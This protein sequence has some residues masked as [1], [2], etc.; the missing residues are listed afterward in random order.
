MRKFVLIHFLLFMIIAVF[1]K[2]PWPFLLLTVAQIVYVPIALRFVMKR[3]DWF[4]SFYSYFAIP[5]YISIAIIQ[6]FS[7]EWSAIPAI[8]YLAFTVIIAL[9]GLTRFLRRGF[10]NIEEFSIDLGMMYI[11]LGGGWYF[12][13]IADIDTGFTPLL[14]WLTGIHFHYSALLL[15]IFIGLL[16]RLYKP[17]FYS[18]F[19]GLLLAAPMVVAI[20]ITFSRWIELFSVLLYIVG[21]AGLIAI[22]WR[23]RFPTRMQ[24]WL[25]VTSF[26][27]LGLTIVFSLLYVLGNGFGLTSI[28]I[29]FML[30]FHG[31][32]N[33][34]V[35]ALFGIVGWAL[36]VPS[37]VYEEP[38][39]PIS[40]VKGKQ[41]IEHLGDPGKHRGLVDNMNLYGIN[42]V[43]PRILDFYENTID[44]RLF[45]TVHWHAWFKPFAFLYSFISRRTEQINLPLHRN[46]V[47]MTGDILTIY[48]GID[49]RKDVRAWI[50]KVDEQY[51]FVALYSSHQTNEGR[52]FMNI[53]LP[54][55]CST[56]TG[57]LEMIEH[58]DDLQLTSRKT[59]P[60][61]DAGIYLTTK[62]GKYFSLPLE[63]DFVVRE[64]GDGSLTARHEMWIFSIPFLTIHYRIHKE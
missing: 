40:R 62:L 41:R 50:R 48:D 27:S 35:F 43:S 55:P 22:A 28:T 39:F 51:A 38:N 37:S 20:G 64:E 57:V 17:N 6:L 10:T 34:I 42:K 5:A 58:G 31:V 30:R 32:L 23:T 25:I 47:E 21:L 49:G 61:S 63:E 4:S 59:C 36:C 13:Y 2:E 29:D 26:T 12:A 14:T 18:F 1:S 15:P 8:I 53:A 44:Y 24:K 45:S 9:Y 33:C 60:D 19:T 16:G 52:N 11:A 3:G 7:P 54:L 56:M 46:E